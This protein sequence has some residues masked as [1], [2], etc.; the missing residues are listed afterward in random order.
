MF[1]GPQP[2][3]VTGSSRPDSQAATDPKVDASV[4]SHSNWPTLDATLLVD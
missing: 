4:D 1:R 2:P 3:V